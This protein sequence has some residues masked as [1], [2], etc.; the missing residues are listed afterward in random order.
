ME[1]FSQKTAESLNGIAG[2]LGFEHDEEKKRSQVFDSLSNMH[3]LSNEDKMVITMRLCKN[4]QELSMF[5]SLSQ[6]NKSLMV[7]MMH[8]GRLFRMDNMDIDISADGPYFFKA[9]VS[10]TSHTM[11]LPPATHRHYRGVVFPQRF[12]IETIEGRKYETTLTVVNNCPTLVDGWREFIHSEDI[13]IGYILVFHPR[14]IFDFQV[15]VMQ[16]NGCERPPQYNVEIKPT[17]VERARLTIPMP[18][19]RGFI[20][21]RY[22]NYNSAVLQFGD[23]LYD[24]DV[25]HGHGKKLIQNGRARQFIDNN[26]ISVGDVCTFTLLQHEDVIKFNVRK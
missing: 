25:I 20:Q 12:S 21:G 23:N 7:K 5:F 4:P 8:E 16:P 2:R 17:H 10:R 24:I 26:N 22:V 15:L 3:F 6:D 18:F 9:I 11:A 1:S 19:W 14:T 13:S